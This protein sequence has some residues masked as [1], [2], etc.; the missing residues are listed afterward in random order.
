MRDLKQLLKNKKVGGHAA[1]DEKSVLY[2]FQTVM[3]EEYGRQGMENIKFFSYGDNMIFVKTTGSAWAN[4][5]WLRKEAIVELINRQL[6]VDE[7]RDISM[8]N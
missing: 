6:G 1:L 7:I 2:V 4:E 3:K 5:I 8:A